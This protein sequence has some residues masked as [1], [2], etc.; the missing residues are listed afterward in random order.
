MFK[1][2][3]IVD[4]PLTAN[5]VEVAPARVVPP[6]KVLLPENVLKSA[7]SVVEAAP[8]LVTVPQTIVPDELTLSAFEPEQV[9]KIEA[10][11]VEPV[12][13]TEK[14]VVVAVPADEEPMAKSVEAA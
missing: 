2:P 8:L 11:L 10:R 14:S 6:V 3:E 7:R 12:E 9:P 5:A 13:E 1:I 4:E